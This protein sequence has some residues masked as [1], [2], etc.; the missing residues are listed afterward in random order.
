MN[1]SAPADERP[2]LPRQVKVMI[3]DDSA[4]IRS[5]LERILRSDPD[6]EVCGFAGNGA[7][8]VRAVGVCRPDIIVLDIEM[9]VMDGITALPLLLEKDPDLKILICSTLSEKGAEIS[10]K[11]LALGAADCILK[12]TGA[13][14]VGANSDF[15]AHLLRTVLMIGA[16]I[17]AAAEPVRKTETKPLP[18]SASGAP[19]IIAVGSSTGGPN[20]LMTVLADMRDMPVP[21]V[22]TQHMPATF[23]R[24]LAEQIAKTTGLDCREAADGMVLEP[25]C[26]YVAAGDRHLLFV[27]AGDG[28]QV[29]LDDGPPEHFCRPAVDPM[30]RSL[31][32]IYGNG[33]ILAVILTGMGHDGLA[34]CREVAAHGGTVV[35]QDAESSVVWGMPG[36]VAGAGL[37][38]A[39]L[40]LKDI[41]A[42]VRGV[43]RGRPS[44]QTSRISTV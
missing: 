8:A 3:V 39:V 34:G 26:A 32:R 10:L 36:A 13:A 21:I 19:K 11:A 24:I 14:A 16:S 7:D 43:V 15:A 42:W 6:I 35:A 5:I 33:G 12:P 38:N 18:V 37:C 23:T 28:V 20:A 44:T 40:P 17:M 22:I 30:L 29:R 41:A 1:D 25:G 4:V 31:V 2:P 27:R 9:P